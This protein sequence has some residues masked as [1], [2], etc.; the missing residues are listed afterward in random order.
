MVKTLNV[1]WLQEGE[2]MS[3]S[4]FSQFFHTFSLFDFFS[5]FFLLFNLHLFYSQH[6]FSIWMLTLV[7]PYS[8]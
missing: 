3:L 5:P 7:C 1:S 4:R 6:F 8:F 2:I